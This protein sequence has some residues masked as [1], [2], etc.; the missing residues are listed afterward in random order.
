M[1]L[2]DMLLLPQISLLLSTIHRNNVK[3][4]SFEVICSIYKQ[5]YQCVH[6]PLNGY[7]NPGA[8]ITHTPE[9]V[10]QLLLSNNQ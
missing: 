8:L 6:D 2:P 3:Q 10:Q 9:Q 7:Q 4:R 1:A 5:L